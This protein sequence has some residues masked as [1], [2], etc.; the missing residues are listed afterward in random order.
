[1]A[2]QTIE[3]QINSGVQVKIHSTIFLY[4]KEEWITAI[5]TRLQEIEPDYNK[6]QDTITFNWR[7]HQQ[8]KGSKILQQIRLDLGI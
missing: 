8:T 1:M 4:S 3:G 7:S 2:R 6:E 5:G